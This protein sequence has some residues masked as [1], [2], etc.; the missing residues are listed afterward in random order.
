[1]S[2]VGDVVFCWHCA[3]SIDGTI[4]PR[5][6]ITSSF[7]W[8]QMLHGSNTQFT[9][10]LDNVELDVTA[11][12]HSRNSLSLVCCYGIGLYSGDISQTLSLCSF[13]YCVSSIFMECK[14]STMVSCPQTA[15][16][17]QHI[18]FTNVSKMIFFHIREIVSNNGSEKGLLDKKKPINRFQFVDFGNFSN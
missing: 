14:S 6:K 12:L 7:R 18:F 8:I 1:M 11:I 9:R 17:V 2:L 15:R 4:S 5:Q 13:M 16:M 3:N 10:V